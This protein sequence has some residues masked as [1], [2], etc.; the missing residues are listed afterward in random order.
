MTNLKNTV[1][2]IPHDLS[3]LIVWSYN[4]NYSL[5]LTPEFTTNIIVNKNLI[6]HIIFL[7]SK[8]Y[9]KIN[10]VVIAEKGFFLHC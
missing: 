4:K 1:D 5:I 7:K 6:S 3:H 8:S 10:I 2:P 9:K